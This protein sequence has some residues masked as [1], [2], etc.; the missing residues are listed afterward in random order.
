MLAIAL[1]SALPLWY[2]LVNS[3]KSQV[4]M[5]L[6]PLALPSE[7]TLTNF[8]NAFQDG[9]MIR[10]F[11]NTL[12]VTVVAVAIQVLVGSLAAYGVVLKKWVLTRVVGIILMV[13][14]T[15]PA[16]AT[17][18]PLYKMEASWGLVDS[19]L[20]LILLYSGGA[21]FC[22]FL[23]VGYMRGVPKELFEAAKLDGA[24]PLR[25]YFS[26]VLPVIRPILVTVIVF[27]V[28]GTWNDFLY[29]NVFISSPEKETVVLQ[30][31]NAVSQFGTNW[32]LFMAVTVCA[33]VPIFIFFIFCQKWIVSGLVAGSVKG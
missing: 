9:S 21:V 16:Q 20:G 2:V 3:F 24:R 30:V 6:H 12:L 18:I 31:Y 32:P 8:A 7:L 5:T 26:I 11:L 17:L 10:A 22:Y 4:D 15:V 23:I 19:L 1:V 28:I 29:P 25:I 27:Q 33:L 14:F 13:A